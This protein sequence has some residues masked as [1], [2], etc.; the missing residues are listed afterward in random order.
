MANSFQVTITGRL[1]NLGTPIDCPSCG[2]DRGLTF[3]T[4]PNLREVT[5]SCPNQH[6]WDETRIPGWAVRDQYIQATQ[7]RR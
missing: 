3:S 5:A 4:D 2:T 1:N 7:G 6:I